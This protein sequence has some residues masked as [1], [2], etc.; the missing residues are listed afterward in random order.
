[1]ERRDVLKVLGTAPA[2][3]FLPAAALTAP[4]AAQAAPATAA[5]PAGPYQPRALDA[6]EY[7]LLTVI[8][9]LI[10]P[11]DERTGSATDCGV[12]ACVDD[13]LTIRGELL[14][15]QIRG[16]FLWLDSET[17]RQHGVDFANA[18]KAQQTALMDRIAWPGRAALADQN[19]AAFFNHLRD[20][21]VNAFYSSKM[22][23]K[24]LQYEGNTMV[25]HWVGCPAT[26]LTKLDTSYAAAQWRLPFPRTGA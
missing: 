10:L 17:R 24:D 7:R 3:A 5:T 13:F 12:P 6:H 11:A 20:L 14:L 8:S 18:T 21:V 9:D 23:V 15:D 25:M 2:A 26:V 4:A 16:G 1:M 22:G 19:A